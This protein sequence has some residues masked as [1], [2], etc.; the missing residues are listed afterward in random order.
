LEDDNNDGIGFEGD[1]DSDSE[2]DDDDLVLTEIEARVVA[3][4]A[5]LYA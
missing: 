1:S 2:L 5:K 3:N 4:N